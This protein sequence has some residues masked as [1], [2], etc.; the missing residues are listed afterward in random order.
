MSIYSN[1]NDT[2]GKSNVLALKIAFLFYNDHVLIRNSIRNEIVQR[3]IGAVFS[4]CRST[5]TGE[6]FIYL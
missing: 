3:N 2:F 5:N 4:L 1:S 6:Y